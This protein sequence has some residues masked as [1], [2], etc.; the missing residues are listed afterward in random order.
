MS[1]RIIN[2]DN[3]DTTIKFDGVFRG[4]TTVDIIGDLTDDDMVCVLSVWPGRGYLNHL[5][6]IA[7][8]DDDLTDALDLASDHWDK[9][10]WDAYYIPKDWDWA[11][12]EVIPDKETREFLE[13]WIDSKRYL[14]DYSK[15]TFRELLDFTHEDDGAIYWDPEFLT[16]DALFRLIDKIE[17]DDIDTRY[18]V[19]D[20]FEKVMDYIEAAIAFNEDF[21]S[22][23]HYLSNGKY[24]YG[25][26]FSYEF[27]TLDEFIKGLKE[28]QAA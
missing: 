19:A 11:M 16:K 20:G 27:M 2:N 23:N 3:I 12:G 25:E 26:N 9:N 22:E 4:D 8:Y 18:K 6:A 14:D 10:G 7:T 17:M 21:E 1:K 15:N 28:N 24:V 5:F 13:S